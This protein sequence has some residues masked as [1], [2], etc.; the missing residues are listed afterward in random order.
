CRT[1]DEDR[2]NCGSSRIT[3]S[4]CRLLGC[5]FNPEKNL[6]FRSIPCNR[7]QDTPEDCGWPGV[8]SQQCHQA[9][10]CENRYSHTGAITHGIHWC[11]HP[12]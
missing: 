3:E 2:F 6:C 11:I 1:W 9:G 8:T 4:E 5:C 10:C 12:K 7:P